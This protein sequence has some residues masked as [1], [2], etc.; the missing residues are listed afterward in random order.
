MDACG[1]RVPRVRRVTAGHYSKGS[2]CVTDNLQS[3]G[4]IAWRTS[5]EDTCR[6]LLRGSVV[7]LYIVVEGKHLDCD[8]S[9]AVLLVVPAYVVLTRVNDVTAI[10][11][12][13]VNGLACERCDKKRRRS[14]ELD[15]EAKYN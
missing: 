5:F 8:S 13:T 6:R 14:N 15:C 3:N 4:Q 10:R 12:S 2:P 9:T 7:V 11:D 1:A